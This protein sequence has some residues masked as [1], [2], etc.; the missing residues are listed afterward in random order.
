MA[1]RLLWSLAMCSVVLIAACNKHQD[2]DAEYRS[3]SHWRASDRLTFGI[4]SV[5][6][7]GIYDLSLALR[8]TSS[9]AYPYQQ[10]MIEV[11]QN[12]QAGRGK[13]KVYTDTL[14]CDITDTEGQRTIEGGISI[15]AYEFPIRRLSLPCGGRGK[16]TVRHLMSQYDVQGFSEIGIITTATATRR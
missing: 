11:T 8:A 3:I 12:W 2:W 9:G 6:T 1:V 4:D 13:P 15:Y 7:S 16:I 10:L 14:T 5:E